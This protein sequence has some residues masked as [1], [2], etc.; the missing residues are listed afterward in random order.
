MER[1]KRK[2]V[3]KLLDDHSF[4]F[5]IEWEVEDHWADF[6][7]FNVVS[8]SLVEPKVLD[9]LKKNHDT[10]FDHTTDTAEAETYL[11]GFIKWDGCAEFGERTHYCGA[12]CFLD[13]ILL[14]EFLYKR[15]AEL[16]GRGWDNLDVRWQDTVSNLKVR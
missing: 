3:D 2:S 11:A 10:C 7:V 15:A 16:M 6:K 8:T 14:L 4:G 12:R 5:V 1:I 9:F 13:H